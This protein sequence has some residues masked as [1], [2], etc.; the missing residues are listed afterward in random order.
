[1]RRVVQA[2]AAIALAWW[3]ATK[4]YP[5]VAQIYSPITHIQ[6]HIPTGK[7]AARQQSIPVGPL[8]VAKGPSLSAS[9]V[10]GILAAY[11]S[12]LKGHGKDIVALSRTYVVDDAVAL[13]FFVME[14]RAGTQGEAV[15][16]RSFGNLRPMPHQPS[17]DGYRLYGTWMESAKEWFGLIH[18]LYVTQL[19]LRTVQDIVPVYAPSTDSNNP[20]TMVAGI[21]QLVSCWRGAVDQCPS[22]PASVP[23]IVASGR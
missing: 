12:P 20:D 18:N 11:G 8:D 3:L 6:F 22:D 14:S 17:Y 9:K 15:T 5:P 1:M 2:V 13:A 16:T 4:L 19:K 21:K 10:D 7:P 23:I